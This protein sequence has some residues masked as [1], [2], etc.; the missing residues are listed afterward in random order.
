MMQRTKILLTGATGLVGT[1]LLEVL[2]ANQY[3]V[4]VLAKANHTFPKEVNH[5]VFDAAKDNLKEAL[6]TEVVPDVI[7][8]NAGVK[9]IGN[10][11]E[12]LS[13]IEKVNIQFSE[14]LIQ[15]A[16]KNKIA[17]FLFTSTFSAISRPLPELITEQSAV[18]P[19]HAYGNSKMIIE[20]KLEDAFL[21]SETDYVVFRLSSPISKNLSLLPDTI[22]RKW[23]VRASAGQDLEL[24]GSGLRFQDF[25][26]T[27]DF[28]NLILAAVS[29]KVPSGTYNAGSG[30]G[31]YFY[32]IANLIANKFKV[33]VISVGEENPEQWRIGMD[34]TKAVFQGNN[35]ESSH[36]LVVELINNWYHANSSVK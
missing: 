31:I 19:I 20:K 26:S 25:I 34:K 29:S 8:H 27:Q 28:A 10:S 24:T 15:F 21:N 35:F 22:L 6:Q 7:V 13:L 16:I 18:A 4:S 1:D 23:L 5:I 36:D 11:E 3:E 14:E 2:L 17:K 12:E 32:E 9:V 33:N 30:N